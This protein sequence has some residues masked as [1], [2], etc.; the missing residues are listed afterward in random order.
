MTDPAPKG[1]AVV[2]GSPGS[3]KSAL[4]ALPVLLTEQSWRT[5]LLR[6]AKP[7][8]LIQ[9]TAG[10][11]PADTPVIAIHARGLNTDQVAA[12][13]AQELGRDSRTASALLD[14]LDARPEPSRRILIVDAVDE[15]ASPTLL[16][17]LLVP[18]ARQR[19]LRVAVGARRHVLSAAGEVDL[20]ID[21]D[22]RDYQDPQALTDYIHELLIA[23][24][25]PGVT[26]A[27]QRGSTPELSDRNGT[28]RVVAAA[29]AERATARGGTSESFLIGRLLAL[30]VRDR[31]EAADVT[32]PAWQFQLPASVA[33]AFDEDLARL[34]D[35]QALARVLLETL[36][37]AKGPGMP[38]ENIWVQVARALARLST[39]HPPSITN[40]EIRWLLA[41]AGAYVVEDVGPGNGRCSGR[42]MT[43]SQCTCGASRTP[44]RSAQTRPLRAD[45]SAAAIGRSKPSRALFLLLCKPMR[46]PGRTGNPRTHTYAPTSHNM[47]PL[48]GQRRPRNYCKTQTSSPWPTRERL[49]PELPAPP[50]GTLDTEPPIT[51]RRTAFDLAS[52]MQEKL[53]DALDLLQDAMHAMDQLE[54]R[55]SQ[56]PGIGGWEY[57]D[58]LAVH[59]QLAASVIN[60]ARVVESSAD[61][62][63]S[64]FAKAEVDV[65]QLTSLKL[66]INPTRLSTTAQAVSGLE[67][68][69]RRLL[70]RVTLADDDL[71][72]RSRLCS[73]YHTPLEILYRARTH[74]EHARVLADS[75]RKGLVH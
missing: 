16:G 67:D 19:G 39:R 54:R 3:G 61:R 34:G 55:G 49:F 70:T 23:S 53:Q 66:G 41:R 8:S 11:V 62:V 65:R 1:L 6:A 28:A 7:A 31:P 69:S 2:T 25:E 9:R 37:W 27:Y 68:L 26:T 17:G 56:P 42:S 18:L 50:L 52:R 72:A 12:V 46:T 15:A 5:D 22:T 30:A 33:E 36:A 73:D 75:I 60:P 4:L 14:D 47:Q 32:S 71:H 13:L 44:S 24:E 51:Y 20:T 45:G 57:V 58:Q 63:V 29:I 59:E 21:L 48:P 43:C 40:E 10:L 38:W 74:I 35:K 64:V